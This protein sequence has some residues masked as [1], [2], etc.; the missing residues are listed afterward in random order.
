MKLKV[1]DIVRFNRSSEW[2]NRYPHYGDYLYRVVD[3]RSQ[4]HYIVG[5]FP[6]TPGLKEAWANPR[7]ETRGGGFSVTDLEKM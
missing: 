7:N 4:N 5:I 6:L 3:I 1:G 2:L